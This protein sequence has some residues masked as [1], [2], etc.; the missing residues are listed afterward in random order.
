MTQ[1]H[2]V[3][4]CQ[5]CRREQSAQASCGRCSGTGN[6]PLAVE[7]ELWVCPDCGAYY[8]AS[9]AGDLAGGEKHAI[10]GEDRG[11]RDGCPYCPGT[12][13]RIATTVLVPVRA[14]RRVAA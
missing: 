11:W 6:E 4:E 1:L 14:E 13:E 3:G 7:V 5:G 2:G 9:S 10:T 12:R 8:G